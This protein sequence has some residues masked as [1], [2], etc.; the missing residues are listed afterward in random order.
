MFDILLNK[1]LIKNIENKLEDN[2]IGFHPGRST[3]DNIFIV[4]QIFEK[5]REHSIDL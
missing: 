1:R 5:S 3:T 4:R 2:Q